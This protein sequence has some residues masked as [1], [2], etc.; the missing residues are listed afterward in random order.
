M[1]IKKLTAL[2]LAVLMLASLL[3]MPILTAINA[4]ASNSLGTIAECRIDPKVETIK[5]A[6]S[7]KHNILVNNRSGKLAVFR[8]APWEDYASLIE[9]EAPAAVMDMT[10]RFE[11]ELP[12]KTVLQRMSR[13]AV[14]IIDEEGRVSPIS[15][16]KYADAATADT[17]RT[18]FKSVITNDVAAASAS[19]AGS[20]VIDVYLD[21]LDNGNKSGYIFNA[22]GELFYFDRSTVSDL[23][24][25]V[26]A[27]TASGCEVYFRF[28]I[29]PYANGLDFCS[30]GN[31]WASNKCVVIN[32][33]HALN[34]I[35]A[36]THFLMSRYDGEDHGRANGIILGRGADMPILYNYASLVS[37]KY[38][39]V[40]ARSLAIIGLAA[41]EAAGDSKISLI[42]PVGDTL[43]DGQ[44]V[45]AEGFLNYISEYLETYTKL[46]FT[47]MCESRHN[48]YKMTDANF[49]TEIIPEDTSEEETEELLYP[50]TAA[51]AETSAAP[52][53]DEATAPEDTTAPSPETSAVTEDETSSAEEVTSPPE[54]D[55]V[56]EP[57]TTPETT[58]ETTEPE[59]PP[60]RPK[61]SI[62]SDSDGYFCTD[63][64]DTFLKFFSSLKKK[65]S[66]VNDGFGWCW[67][68]ASDSA[69]SALGVCYSY[70]YM[71]L[72][73]VGADFYAV[74]FENDV[75]DRFA[76]IS[77]LFKYIDTADNVSETEYARAALGIGDWSDLISGYTS[78]VG[79]YNTLYENSL[80]PNVAG[81]AGSFVYLDHT[82]GNGS[83]GW[84]EG[85]YCD[86]LGIKHT[87]GRSALLANMNLDLA[88]VNQAEIGY[89]LDS[90]EPLL[91]GDALTFEIKCG[92][93]DGSLYELAISLNC[94]NG[95]ITSKTVIAGGAEC[96]VSIDVSE[97]DKTAAVNAMKITLKR[98]TGS[99]DCVLTLS[100]VLINSK[101][102]SDN[103]LMREFDDIRDY[104]RADAEADSRDNLRKLVFCAVV[105]ISV[106]LA[107]LVIAFGNDRRRNEEKEK[108]DERH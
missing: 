77:H 55:E 82:K 65:Y 93:D 6:G 66:S 84:Y 5:I 28:L 99:G 97:H 53:T 70:N 2:V 11:F 83:G 44:T 46:K 61:P 108:Y 88:G 7:I 60:E 94:S 87:D 37:E 26:L 52:E 20:A 30:D 79:V 78:E 96:S 76:S 13:Y 67:Y 34:A 16:P 22:D 57:D 59:G 36:F 24:K 21:Q 62:N 92:E 90:P 4:S 43:V 54:T 42:V 33:E 32:D 10:I 63:N 101:T 49:S 103:I 51:P 72:A 29:S 50:E 8:F 19:H 91:L 95:T 58:P 104:L 102:E 106:G 75:I 18:G 12:C 45:Y 14:A 9:T 48:P 47:V 89:I 74:A 81:Y 1:N 69:E 86:S 15:E 100:R 105:L 39:E 56:T 107:A 85:L 68:P 98:V 3:T 35:Y 71:K 27:Y 17:S 80:E 64:L 23:D 41:A 25:K 38:E 31:T 40:Y 73:T